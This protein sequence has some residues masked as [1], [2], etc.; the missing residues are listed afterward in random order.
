[1]NAID[2]KKETVSLRSEYTKEQAK[3]IWFFNELQKEDIKILIEA[4]FKLFDSTNE[5]LKKDRKSR[6]HQITD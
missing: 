5:D 6:T 1:M 3:K 4:A 2:F